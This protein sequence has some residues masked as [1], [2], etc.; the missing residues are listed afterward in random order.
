MELN[1]NGDWVELN[2]VDEK[3]FL[4]WEYVRVLM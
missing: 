4:E 3:I 1:L 2:F